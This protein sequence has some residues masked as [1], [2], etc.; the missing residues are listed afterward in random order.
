MS[1]RSQKRRR[2]RLFGESNCCFWCGCWLVH[3]E[4]FGRHESCPDN[5]AT[6]DHL[7]DRLNPKR[8]E[9]NQN[10]EPRT[11]LSCKKCNELNGKKSEQDL[12]DGELQRRSSHT[13][14]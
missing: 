8:T 6:L 7:R 3:P 1:A 5:M 10:C 14:N 2:D 11:V 12:S 9:P 4:N 13:K